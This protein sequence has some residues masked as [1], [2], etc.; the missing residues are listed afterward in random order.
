MVFLPPTGDIYTGA[1]RAPTFIYHL[2]FTIYHFSISSRLPAHRYLPPFPHLLH[3]PRSFAYTQDDGRR[4]EEKKWTADSSRCPTVPLVPHSP[5]PS[6]H[7]PVPTVSLS[8]YPTIPPAHQ[9]TSSL[10]LYI[11]IEK[12]HRFSFLPSISSN[13]SLFN[14]YRH[15]SKFPAG[16]RRMRGLLRTKFVYSFFGPLGV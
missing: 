5:V 4:R 6:P 12:F 13:S 14:E 15:F 16:E 8:H 9:P 10:S 7:P 1:H 11:P 3:V 2:P